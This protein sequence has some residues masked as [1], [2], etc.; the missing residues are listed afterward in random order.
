MRMFP[1]QVRGDT[2]TND[3]WHTALVF[4]CID[5]SGPKFTQVESPINIMKETIATAIIGTE[6]GW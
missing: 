5:D 4:G 2:I 6:S 1:N 3:V